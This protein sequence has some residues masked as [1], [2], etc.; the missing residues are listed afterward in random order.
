MELDQ[1]KLETISMGFFFNS[2]L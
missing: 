2:V 1:A